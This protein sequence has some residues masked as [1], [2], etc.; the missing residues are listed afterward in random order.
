MRELGDAFA[1]DH[2]LPKNV[3]EVVSALFGVPTG[4]GASRPTRDR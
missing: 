1:V 3:G 2:W 4:Y